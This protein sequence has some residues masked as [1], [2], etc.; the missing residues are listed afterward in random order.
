MNARRKLIRAASAVDG[1]GKTCQLRG[2]CAVLLEGDHVLAAGSAQEIGEPADALVVDLP[3]MLLMPALVNAHAHLDLTHIG[4]AP[5]TGD[6]VSWVAMIRQRRARSDVEIAASVAQG[7][8]RSLAGGVC[9]IGDIAGVGSPAAVE[10]LRA[11]GLSGVSYLEFF[12]QGR[13]QPSTI[14]LMRSLVDGLP[15]VDR[16]VRLGVQPHAPYSCGLAVYEAA[17]GLGLPLATH[18]AETP[19]E[20]NFVQSGDGPLAELL[21]AIGVWD[22]TITGC[23]KHPIDALSYVFEQ[24]A[25]VAA[26]LN[27]TDERHIEMLARWPLSVAYCPRASAYFGHPANTDNGSEEDRA[28]GHQYRAMIDAGVNV[29]LGTDSIVCLD[30]PDRISPLDEMRFLYRRDG[31]DPVSLLRMASTAGASALGLEPDLATFA[32]GRIAGVIGV[33]ID[34]GDSTDPL[35][36]A[37]RSDAAPAWVAGPFAGRPQQAQRAGAKRA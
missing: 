7:A 12:G 16:G 35:I 21:R 15:H 33:A 8:E 5:Y 20:I 31:T 37:M 11:S 14:A 19:E 2:P 17:A 3:G 1:R 22:E 6:F 36:Q 9:V 4:P 24:S 27:Y 18:L 30:T 34:P 32:P 13:T 23:G 29:A 28:A 26:H 25:A 10:A